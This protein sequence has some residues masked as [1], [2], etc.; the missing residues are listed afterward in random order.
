MSL[1]PQRL[2][3]RDLELSSGSFMVIVSLS[4]TKFP[5]GCPCLRL[6]ALGTH[7]LLPAT[8]W[9]ASCHHSGTCSISAAAATKDPQNFT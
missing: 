4:E 5:L 6:A 9:P 2:K 1:F 3:V 7:Y 8:T